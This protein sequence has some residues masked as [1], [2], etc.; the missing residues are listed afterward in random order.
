MPRY[1]L[2][3]NMCIYL[4]KSQPEQVAKRFAQCYT[5]DVVM[6]AITYA[7][8]EYGVTLCA[9][10]AR[11]RRHLAALIEDIPVAPFDAAAAQA[12]G[13]VRD[14][15]RA[16]KKDHLDKLIAAHAVSLDVVLVTNDERDFASYPGLR[17][18]NWLND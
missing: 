3:T 4:M 5:G 13:P 12:Y 10:P 6:S 16:W 8:L 18:E 7:E 1:M 14:A 17:L 11:E 9:A 2:D 15:T